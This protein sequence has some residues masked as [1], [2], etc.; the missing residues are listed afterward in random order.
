MK[1]PEWKKIGSCV[2]T[3]LFVV[4]LV[5]VG[6]LQKTARTEVDVI[7]FAG[8]SNMSGVGDASLAPVVPKGVGYEFRAITDPTRLY[9]LAEPFG[10]NEHNPGM[11][12][13]RGLL[14]RTGSLVSAFV[15]SYYAQTRTPVV[16]VSAS[17]GSSKMHTWLKENG[18]FLDAGQRLDACLK[19][20]NADP[21]Y[22][23]R[24]IYM[25]W[26]QGESDT[27]AKKTPED[28]EEKLTELF[29]NFKILGVEKCFVIRIG[30]DLER[31]SEGID[32]V[33]EAQTELC[34]T[35]EDFVLVS[36]QAV[37]LNDRGMMQDRVHYTQE[38][39]NFIGEEAGTNAGSYVET[40]VEPFMEDPYYGNT[41]VPGEESE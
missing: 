12:D 6:V 13:D 15:N 33:I 19:Y 14:E 16:A 10:E 25:V 4:L 7:L 9:P 37:T 3:A 22:K 21:S 28:Y 18:L 27:S 5:A 40:G 30:L 8:Q 24:H 41:Y 38:G 17:R 20:L 23:I 39:Y 29:D 32:H 26:L 36:T 34:R 2:V 35:S 1:R 31:D 11:C